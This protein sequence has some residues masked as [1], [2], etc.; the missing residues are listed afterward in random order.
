MARNL[1]IAQKYYD[2]YHGSVARGRLDYVFDPDDFADEWIF[3]SPYLGGE[4]AQGR[5]TFLAEGAVANHD[6][7]WKRIPDYKMDHFQAW[8]TEAGCA[9]RWCVNGHGLD[10]Q[11]LEFW[12]QLFIWTDDAGRITRFEFYDDWHGFPHT[13]TYAY[14]VTLDQFSR[15]DGYGSAP[16]TPGPSPTIGPPAILPRSD[17]PATDHTARNLAIAQQC[18]DAYR[19]APEVNW[20]HTLAA[21]NQLAADCVV[22]SPWFGEQAT[23]A[24]TQVWTVLAIGHAKIRHRLPD[25]EVSHFEAWPNDTGCAWRWRLSGHALDGTAYEL[26]QQVF[27]ETD[28]RGKATRLESYFDWQGFPQMLGY[29]TGIPLD[30]LWHAARYQQWINS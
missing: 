8:P 9:W 16:W 26:W 29:V 4:T 6:T 12:E 5:S 15:I 25:F 17:P 10:G 3:C 30:E 7:I 21:E 18:F 14:D 23:S 19:S 24:Q 27:V 13:L 28:D 2:G 20:L 1:S 22:F 11:E